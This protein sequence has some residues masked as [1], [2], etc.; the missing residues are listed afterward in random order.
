MNR[1]L[2]FAALA[3]AVV[4]VARREWRRVNAELDRTRGREVPPAGTLRRDAV[5]GEWRPSR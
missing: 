3:A 5:T 4:F 1:L 2:P